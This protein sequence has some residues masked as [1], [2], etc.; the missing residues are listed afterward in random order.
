MRIGGVIGDDDGEAAAA[1]ALASAPARLECVT[2]PGSLCC[3]CCRGCGLD[4]E[5]AHSGRRRRRQEAAADLLFIR[6]V[7]KVLS[8]PHCFK[9]KLDWN[10]RAPFKAA[11]GLPLSQFALG[12]ARG[13]TT[14]TGSDTCPSPIDKHLQSLLTPTELR[15]FHHLFHSADHAARLAFRGR[16]QRIKLVFGLAPTRPPSDTCSP[17]RFPPFPPLNSSPS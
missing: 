15:L 14:L 13:T 17:A 16:A 11:L 3:C 1:A 9:D 7:V 8:S 10:S 4:I 5:S 6:N 2:H 12:S